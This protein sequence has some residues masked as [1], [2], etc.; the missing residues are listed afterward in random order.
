M[1]DLE[2]HSTDASGLI[3]VY[4]YSSNRSILELDLSDPLSLSPPSLAINTSKSCDFSNPITRS[5]RSLLGNFTNDL[6]IH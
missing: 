1:F 5:E 6:E 4:L 2:F 3:P